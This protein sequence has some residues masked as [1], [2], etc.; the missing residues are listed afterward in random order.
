[1]GSRASKH[2]HAQTNSSGADKRPGDYK[3]GLLILEQGERAAVLS[4][5]GKR[6]LVDGPCAMRPYFS[7]VKLLERHTCGPQDYLVLMYN[8]GTKE[9]KRGPASVFFDSCVHK[10]IIVEPAIKL[11]ANEAIIVYREEQPNE[12]A[13]E[14]SLKHKQPGV[15]RRVVQGPTIF[16]PCANEWIHE[17]SWHGTPSLYDGVKGSI[18]GHHDDNKRA[19]AVN[20]S[21]LRLM[22]DQIYLA[23]RDVRTSDDATLTLHVMIFFECTDVE[24]M[25]NTTNDPISDLINSASADV[26]CFGSK[27]TFEELLADSNKLSETETYPILRARLETIGYNL[28]KVV[29]RAYNTSHQL[30]AMQESAISSRTKLRLEADT[31]AQE[32]KN[33]LSMLLAREEHMK[34][35]NALREKEEQHKLR[36][37]RT[38]FEAE[39]EQLRLSHQYKLDQLRE[40]NNLEVAHTK[41]LNDERARFLTSLDEMGVN[42]TQ[43]LVA[44]AAQKPDFLIASASTDMVPNVHVQASRGSR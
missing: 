12:Q 42:V 39:Q 34:H 13:D 11:E 14:M 5:D 18:T 35:E 38:A 24:K 32:E 41:S 10:Q 22:P 2:Q 4:R 40:K 6:T 37:R 19:H 15:A 1:M 26:M 9:H 29:Y 27:R 17:F 30:Q 7:T 23:V 43:Y 3:F 21:R 8:D 31:V 33:K 28:L 36:M 25:L 44:Q 16:C 20:F